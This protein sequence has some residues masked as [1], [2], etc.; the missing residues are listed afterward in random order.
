MKKQKEVKTK[1]L[2]ES[3]GDLPPPKEDKEEEDP[4]ED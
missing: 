3:F 1:N 2:I 4:N